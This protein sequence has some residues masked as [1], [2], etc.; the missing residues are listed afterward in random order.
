M[1]AKCDFIASLHDTRWS[2]GVQQFEGG[3]V[4]R[5]ETDDAEEVAEKLLMDARRARILRKLGADARD[6]QSLERARQDTIKR[7]DG[8]QAAS[9]SM[10][11][12]YARLPRAFDE[13]SGS[14]VAEAGWPVAERATDGVI[15][16][17]VERRLREGDE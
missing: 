16:A 11:S 17:E 12:A 6:W 2:S 10:V 9:G 3:L 7:I 8:N 1:T 5:I 15:E 14:L 13:V 4:I